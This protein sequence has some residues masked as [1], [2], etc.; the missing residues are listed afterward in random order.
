VSL[1]EIKEQARRDL[2]NGM[3]VSALYLS[4]WPVEGEPVAIPCEVRVHT[5]FK[6]LGDLAGTSLGYAETQEPVPRLLFMKDQVDPVNQAV[7]SISL[8]EAY[9]IVLV[10]PADG[11]TVTA[12]V[13]PMSATQRVGLPLPEGV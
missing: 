9:R 4:E 11:I 2:H 6:A 12:E 1:R 7:V 8:E 5:K 13:T 3:K 10:N